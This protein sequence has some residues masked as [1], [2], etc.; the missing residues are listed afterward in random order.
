MDELLSC[1]NCEQLKK[2]GKYNYKTVCRWNDNSN[3][4]KIQSH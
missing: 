4:C 1:I 3:T 2:K